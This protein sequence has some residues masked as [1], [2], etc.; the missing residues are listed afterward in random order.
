MQV[1]LRNPLADPYVLGVS[2][3]AATCALLALSAGLGSLWL[4]GAAFS[5]A[6]FS[7]LLVFGLAHG[8]GAW[9]VNR[10]LLTGVVVAA[11]WGAVI[12]FLL[13]AVTIQLIPII[14]ETIGWRFAFAVLAI[15]PLL[16]IFAITATAP[17][18][19]AT[20]ACRPSG[21]AATV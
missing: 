10:L 12:G 17:L 20:R 3:G 15:G 5:G 6:L 9:T 4:H 14:Q 1:L 16:G 19:P 8:R 13:T 18:L 2:G 7:M 21:A 11:G